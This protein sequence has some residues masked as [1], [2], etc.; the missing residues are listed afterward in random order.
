MA[1][2][3]SGGHSTIFAV[4]GRGAQ[5]ETLVETRDDAIGEAFDKFG[6]R[7]GLPYPQGPRVDELAEEGA[8][9]F[10][11]PVPAP[12]DP[13]FFSYSGLKTR[14]VQEIERLERPGEALP[15]AALCASFRRAAVAQVID[16]LA[17]LL[18]RRPFASLAVSGGVAANRLLRR[19][20][21]TWAEASGV[22]LAL[23]P[24]R[25]SGDN[26]A[27]IAHAALLRRRRGDP[28]DGFDVEAESRIA[29]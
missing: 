28:G 14:A 19:E 8:E 24:L 23:V 21:Q 3:V 4:T 6:K 27:M 11:F 22:T 15:V 10:I 7:L 25:Y 2:V 29:I 12:G 16:R 9:A 20:L 1:L 5:L 13:D 26:A 17:R 18:R